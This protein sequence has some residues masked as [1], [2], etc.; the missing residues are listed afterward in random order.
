MDAP[1]KA[2]RGKLG[3]TRGNNG[4]TPS[5]CVTSYAL[6]VSHC[7]GVAYCRRHKSHSHDVIANNIR[8]APMH[9]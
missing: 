5:V 6:F 9:A 8:L 2:K 4:D 7:Y 1:M 3:E